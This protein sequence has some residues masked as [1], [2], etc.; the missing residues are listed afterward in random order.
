MTGFKS[1]L[2]KMHFC[3]KFTVPNVHRTHLDG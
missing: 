2:G 3:K 1:Y